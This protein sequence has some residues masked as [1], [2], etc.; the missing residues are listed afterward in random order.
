MKIN[1]SLK[2]ISGALVL[3]STLS[4]WAGSIVN[5]FTVPFD[6]TT[7]GV[8]GTMWDGIY[9]GQGDVPGSDQ[10]PANGGGQ[11]L[12]ADTTTFAN[13]LYVVSTLGGW[14]GNQ[15]DGFFLYKYVAGNFDV[16][17]EILAATGFEYQAQN[18]QFAGLLA[19]ATPFPQGLPYTPGAT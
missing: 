13:S 15:D 5:N 12:T 6:F 2:L 11:T 3:A 17:V 9:L 10:N 4:V 7:N 1:S 16:S 8:A 18:F 19:R 14:E